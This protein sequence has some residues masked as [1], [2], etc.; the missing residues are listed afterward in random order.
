MKLPESLETLFGRFLGKTPSVKDE[1]ES[2]EV[3]NQE[4]QE[5]NNSTLE[6]A[7]SLNGEL[8]HLVT[9]QTLILQEKAQGLNNETQF[10]SEKVKLIT[11]FE[12]TLL[13]KS[14]KDRNGA[15]DCTNDKELSSYI[16]AL[17]KEDMKISGGKLSSDDVSRILRELQHKRDE[18]NDKLRQKTQEFQQC[19]SERNTLY[20]FVM[21]ILK[22][23]QRSVSRI[24]SLMTSR[25]Q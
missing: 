7:Q 13:A 11:D 17:Q 19:V 24:C 6:K 16:T 5:A 4:V 8:S 10:L 14:N 22:D 18:V 12:S 20:S 9:E 15:V 23:I 21:S 2:A 25:G 3:A 1:K